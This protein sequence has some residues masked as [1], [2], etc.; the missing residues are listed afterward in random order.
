MG[1]T[2]GAAVASVP[3]WYFY[4]FIGHWDIADVALSYWSGDNNG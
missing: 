2:D 4:S 3:L 1:H